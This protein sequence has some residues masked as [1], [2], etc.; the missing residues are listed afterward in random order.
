MQEA[1]PRHQRVEQPHGN[2]C[3]RKRP[4]VCVCERER[5][6][7]LTCK[8]GLAFLSIDIKRKRFLSLHSVL[9]QETKLSLVPPPAHTCAGEFLVL[10]PNEPRVRKTNL[11]TVQFYM[12]VYF[13]LMPFHPCSRCSSL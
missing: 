8:F 1:R 2:G 4:C 6:R 11:N 7:T 5:E 3:F 9:R 13:L 12:K 10:V